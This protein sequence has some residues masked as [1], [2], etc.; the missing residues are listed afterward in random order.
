MN[1]PGLTLVLPV[2]DEEAVLEENLRAMVAALEGWAAGAATDFEVVAVD[3]GSRDRSAEVLERFAR[4]DQRLRPLALPH[5]QGKGAAVR[6]GVLAA[7]GER[8]LFLDADLSVPLDH[9]PALLDALEQHDVAIG[10]RRVPG[11]QITRRQ[12]LVRETL[13]R[14]FATLTRTLLAPGI[15]DFTCGFKAFRAEAARSIFERV[16]QHGWAFDAELIVIA[17]EQ[18]LSI[19]QVPVRWQHEEDSKV[20]VG[21]AVFSSLGELARIRSNKQRGRYR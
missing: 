16:T 7:R 3:D 10:S 8:V 18:G 17:L 1:S 21:S 20:R 11:A 5:N 2:Y 12:P 13:G 14:C 15:H 6:H 19:A 9:V 4:N